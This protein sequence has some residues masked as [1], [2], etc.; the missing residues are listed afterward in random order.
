MLRA[1]LFGTLRLFAEEGREQRLD[2]G[3]PRELLCY[4]L[5]NRDRPLP[6]EA[7]AAVFWGDVSTE[8]SKKHLRQ[9]LWHLQSALRSA[10]PTSDGLIRIEGNC[11]VL[12][13]T[14]GLWL[15]VAAVERAFALAQGIPG[16]ALEPVFAEELSAAAA[17]YEGDLLEGW[18]QDWCVFERERLQSIYISVLDK[19]MAY[20]EV[21]RTYLNGIEYGARILRLD[22]A[23]ETTH[24]RLMRLHVLAGNRSEALRQYQRCAAALEKELA[25]RPARST[26]QLLDDIRSER[27]IGDD[28]ALHEPLTSS[29]QTIQD[30]V[31]QLTQFRKVLIDLQSQVRNEVRS[32][33]QLINRFSQR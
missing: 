26:E 4:L 13:S 20:A 1:H 11:V 6:R 8:K 12:D 24:R 3:K 27:P 22:R 9:S 21:Q 28:P 5:L 33:D 16:E 30:F 29:A 19:L 32:V 17:L 18:Y 15:D 14:N 2:F 7:L 10:L 23:R 31:R 25:V